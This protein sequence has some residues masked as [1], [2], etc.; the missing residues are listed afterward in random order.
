MLPY[1]LAPLFVLPRTNTSPSSVTRPSHWDDGMNLHFLYH[2][3]IVSD[4]P[5]ML[6]LTHE[7]QR[8]LE[9]RRYKGPF[10]KRWRLVR[11]TDVSSSLAALRK[12]NLFDLKEFRIEDRLL[13][14]CQHPLQDSRT[15]KENALFARP[16]PIARTQKSPQNLWDSGKMTE[17]KWTRKG[18]DKQEK[19]G[20]N[21]RSCSIRRYLRSIR[22]SPQSINIPPLT[23]M[24]SPVM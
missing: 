8:R 12:N 10:P 21:Q 15:R 9:T 18:K 11:K 6:F 23:S 2:C 5:T 24:I 22:S 4:S 7:F 3:G 16:Y 14:L 1:R 13:L 17:L 20:T 19:A